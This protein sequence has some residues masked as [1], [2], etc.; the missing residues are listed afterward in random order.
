[1]RRRRSGER[2]RG[3]R[4]LVARMVAAMTT[5]GALFVG[6]L[7]LGGAIDTGN[8][9]EGEAPWNSGAIN[10]AAPPADGPALPGGRATL[11]G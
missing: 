6:A 8:E 1:M 2:R 10:D 7:Y 4:R 5:G 11:D 3:D 9:T